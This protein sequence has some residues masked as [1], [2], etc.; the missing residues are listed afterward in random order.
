MMKTKQSIRQLSSFALLVAISFFGASCGDD[1]GSADDGDG[2]ADGG[3]GAGDPAKELVGYWAPDI[4]QMVDMAKKEMPKEQLEA[5]GAAMIEMMTTMMGTMSFEF[6][7]DTAIIHAPGGGQEKSTYKVKSSDAATGKI[8]VEITS[9]DAVE[10]GTA[11]VK[12][13]TLKLTKMEDGKE[14]NIFLNRISEAE[15][16]KRAAAAAEQPAIPGLPSGEKE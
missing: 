16:K 12:G 8:V 9:D 2:S 6:T 15:F 3:G 13:D 1:K 14:D 10:E 7:S 5:G 4:D 11:I